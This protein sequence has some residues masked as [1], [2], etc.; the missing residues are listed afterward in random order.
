M[1]SNY[2]A[3]TVLDS[4][5]ALRQFKEG[6]AIFTLPNTPIKCLGAPQKVMYIAEDY[7]RKVSAY[8][9]ESS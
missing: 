1:G 9:L 5:N 3:D 7:M 4:W 8:T 6:N 2:S